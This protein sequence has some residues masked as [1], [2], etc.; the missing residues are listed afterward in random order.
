M[1]A[2]AG[3]AAGRLQDPSQAATTEVQGGK[4]AREIAEHNRIQQLTG[5]QRAA[6][7]DAVANQRDPIGPNRRPKLGLPEPQ[8]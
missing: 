2:P 6:N 3:G 8:E 5:G 1:P 7:S 4:T